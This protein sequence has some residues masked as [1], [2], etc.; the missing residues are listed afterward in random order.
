[1]GERQDSRSFVAQCLV[2]LGY[3]HEKAETLVQ[4]ALDVHAHEL[5]EK[6]RDFIGSEEYVSDDWE[7]ACAVADLIDPEVQK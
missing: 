4:R 2:Q 1:M 6:Q 5:A 7:A 3:S